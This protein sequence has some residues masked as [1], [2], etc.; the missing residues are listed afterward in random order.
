MYQECALELYKADEGREYMFMHC[1]LILKAIP[2]YDWEAESVSSDAEDTTAIG[3]PMG[4]TMEW[5]AGNRATKDA[6]KAARAKTRAKTS[7]TKKQKTP[8]TLSV[9]GSAAMEQLVANSSAMAEHF[10]NLALRNSLYLEF[11]MLM[12]MGRQNEANAIY[13]RM[14]QLTKPEHMVNG[15]SQR[16]SVPQRVAARL[17]MES[18]SDESS[19]EQ[20]R[21][22]AKPKNDAD[23]ATDGADTSMSGS[24]SGGDAAAANRTASRARAAAIMAALEDRDSLEQV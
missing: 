10:N 20:Q 23:Y 21:P 8:D 13:E 17:E 1:S 15:E 3:G 2:K 7:R 14:S 4:G 24:S 19:L 16:N 11:Q 9:E 6:A 18:S 12:R 22:T 5:P